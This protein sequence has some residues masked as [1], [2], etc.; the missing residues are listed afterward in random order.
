MNQSSRPT[1]PRPCVAVVSTACL[2]MLAACTSGAEGPSVITGPGTADETTG[3][4]STSSDLPVTRAR[5]VTEYDANFAGSLAVQHGPNRLWSGSTTNLGWL[6]PSTGT[7]HVV[8]AV[9]GVMLGVYHHTLYRAS[10]YG[11]NVA[12]YDVSGT[13]REVARQ[14]APSPLNILAGPPGVWAADHFH[15][16][17][18]RLD[19]ITMKV[20]E[21]IR[22]GTGQGNGPSGM[23]WQG[24]NMWVNVQRDQTVALVDG[25]TGQVLH[26]VYL[27]G[28]NLGDGISRTS[29]G[30]WAKSLHGEHAATMQLIDTTDFRVI[31]RIHP[32]HPDQSFTPIEIHGETWMLDGHKLWHLS[33]DHHW[34]PD[35]AVDLH[36]PHLQAGFDLVAFG[37]LWITDFHPG[38]IIRVGAQDLE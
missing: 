4:S 36:I 6:D 14:Q 16:N 21:K 18:L 34:Q 38:Q 26:R 13:P 5:H 24:K 37:S 32:T 11:N 1:V 30:I 15:G 25:R 31:A 9:P 10:L 7:T 3:A 12:R 33:A 2:V 22:I 20:L 23:L 35:R 28:T 27:G 29:A 19:P 8:D 17:L